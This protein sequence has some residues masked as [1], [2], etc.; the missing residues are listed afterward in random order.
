MIDILGR[1]GSEVGCFLDDEQT[2]TSIFGQLTHPFFCC[3]A[4]AVYGNTL[5]E[6]SLCSGLS[7]YRY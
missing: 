2:S 4:V 5:T 7:C 1:G 3:F 6:G